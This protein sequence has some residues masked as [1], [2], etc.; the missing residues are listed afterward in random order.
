MSKSF[1]AAY[2][3]LECRNGSKGRHWRK[4]AAEFCL[5][6]WSSDKNTFSIFQNM[7]FFFLVVISFL[8]NYVFYFYLSRYFKGK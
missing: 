7:I 1:P 4:L 2:V 6:V 8:V 5:V 3:A